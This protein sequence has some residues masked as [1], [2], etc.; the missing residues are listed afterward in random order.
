MVATHLKKMGWEQ[1][2]AV[3]LITPITV[4]LEVYL[5]TIYLFCP[6]SIKSCY[7]TG[8]VFEMYYFSFIALV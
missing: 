3:D 1:Q 2:K 4:L 8:N 5:F 7:Y 6:P